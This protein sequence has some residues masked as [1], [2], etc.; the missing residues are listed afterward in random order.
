MTF[1]SGLKAAYDTLGSEITKTF[2][3]QSSLT[4]DAEETNTASETTTLGVADEV[5][6]VKPVHT[7][8]QSTITQVYCLV[9]CSPPFTPLPKVVV[10]L[11]W[12]L[13]SEEVEEMHLLPVGGSGGISQHHKRELALLPQRGQGLGPFLPTPRIVGAVR[14]RVF[15]PHQ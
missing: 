14:R 4:E 6:D 8:T 12:F 13:K 1:F 3:S 2:D 5:S 15:P 11:L 10:V 9:F 7:L